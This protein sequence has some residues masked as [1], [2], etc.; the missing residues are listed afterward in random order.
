MRDGYIKLWRKVWDNPIMRK[1][2]YFSVFCWMLSEA[3]H[4]MVKEGEKWREAKEDELPTKIF[5]GKRIIL[6]SGQFTSGAYQIAENTGVPR[7]TVER[8]IKVLKNE[9]Q[10]EVQTDR[11]CS[12]ITIKNWKQYQMN[13]ERNEERVRN[14]RGTTEER[15]RTTEECKNIKNV[16]KISSTKK[17]PHPAVEAIMTT[18]IE[19]F[20]TL[21][22]TTAKNRQ[23]AWNLYR[24]SGENVEACLALVRGASQHDWWKSRIT[25]VETLYKNA[26]MITNAL[27]EQSSSVVFIS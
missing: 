6:R 5:R 13:E 11:Q 3:C 1:P 18:M 2:A 12:L 16:K 26:H 21:D 8:I 10:I 24:K 25:K 14:D 15:V 19:C 20:G 22:G 9:E 7:G 23:Y 4:G 27:K 17:S